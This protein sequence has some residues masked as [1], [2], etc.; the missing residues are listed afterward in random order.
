LAE[1]V[2]VHDLPGDVRPRAELAAATMS[3]AMDDVPAARERWQAAV[4]HAGD[5]SVSMANA[6][7]GVGLSALAVGD[8]AE[9]ADC[10][11]R[12]LPYAEAGGADGEWTAALS[13]IWLGTVAF[14]DGDPDSAVEHVERGLVSARRR[15]DRLSAYI[16]LYNLS[17]VEL[18]RQRHDRARRHLEEGM[19]LSLETGDHANLAYLL[20]ATAVLETAEGTHARVPLLLGAAQGIREAIGS[21]GYGYYRPDPVAGAAAADEARRHLGPD[22]Y[23]DALDVGRGLRPEEAAALA[24]GERT[25]AG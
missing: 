14:L 15:G 12:A 24:L 20:D 13:L 5:D 21:L 17:Q 23:D 7:A 18:S 19:R 6:V 25:V 11:E 3:F 9:A 2:L 10:F 4:E 8:L 16:A 22:R 1:A